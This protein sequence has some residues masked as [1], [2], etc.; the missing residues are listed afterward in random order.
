MGSFSR[1]LPILQAKFLAYG[2][3]SINSHPLP[4][5]YADIWICSL[6]QQPC[7]RRLFPRRLLEGWLEAL[8]RIRLRGLAAY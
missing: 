2:A 8:L 4:C 7:R 6:A 5:K 1:K 3:M